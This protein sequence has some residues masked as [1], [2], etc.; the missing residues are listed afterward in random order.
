MGPYQRV[1]TINTLNGQAVM[2]E[3]E[4]TSGNTR[5]KPRLSLFSRPRRSH[6]HAAKITNHDCEC[7]IQAVRMVVSTALLA[8]FYAVFTVVAHSS[9]IWEGHR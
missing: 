7:V 2:D 9:T 1:M 5:A 8:M 3:S 6:I 4:V